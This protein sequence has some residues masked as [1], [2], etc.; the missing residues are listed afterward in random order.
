MEARL[1]S[2]RWPEFESNFFYRDSGMFTYNQQD[3]NSERWKAMTQNLTFS[4]LYIVATVN[5]AIQTMR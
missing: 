5:D 1:A 2:A 3:L 4:D